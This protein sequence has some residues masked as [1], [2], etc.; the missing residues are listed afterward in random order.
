MYV[1]IRSDV[2]REELFVHN[3]VFYSAWC[4]KMNELFP[5]TPTTTILHE[6]SSQN[7][8]FCTYQIC[9]EL[10]DILV[11]MNNLSKIQL[12]LK[13]FWVKTRKSFN[14]NVHHW[15]FA[16]ARTNESCPIW[17]NIKCHIECA[18]SPNVQK[19]LNICKGHVWV[20]IR[21]MEVL[22]YTYD[23]CTHI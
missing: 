23:I 16:Q 19:R 14:K 2:I 4:E 10:S 15:S 9:A 12:W 5:T 3:R 1:E 22:L 13:H 11:P 8:I 20:A 17:I 21:G 6:R 7:I 18:Y